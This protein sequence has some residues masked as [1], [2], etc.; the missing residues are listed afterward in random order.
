MRSRILGFDTIAPD[1]HGSS[2]HDEESTLLIRV[3]LDSR[4]LSGNTQLDAF[5]V[6]RSNVA[7]MAW[8]LI[9]H[10][11]STV[12]IDKCTTKMMSDRVRRHRP[13]HL[14]FRDMSKVNFALPVN[15]PL[16]S[17]TRQ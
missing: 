5:T 14:L 10:N 9:I 1:R 12:Q 15:K 3:R 2:F 13:Q 11:S 4:R 6:C 16:A 7:E 17:N 8:L